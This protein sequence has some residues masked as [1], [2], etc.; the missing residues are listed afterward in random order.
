MHSVKA[1]GLAYYM[2]FTINTPIVII[3][4]LLFF[5]KNNNINFN[6][7]AARPM[8]TRSFRSFLSLFLFGNNLI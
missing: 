1:L 2:N 6:K 5:S 3:M 4:Q 8:T 7:G